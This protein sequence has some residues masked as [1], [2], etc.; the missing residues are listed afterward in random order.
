MHESSAFD[1]YEMK[2]R[3]EEGHRLLFRLEWNRF[4]APDAVFTATSWQEFLART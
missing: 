3:V 2:G 4:G 1:L